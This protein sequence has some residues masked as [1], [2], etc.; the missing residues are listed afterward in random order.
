MHSSLSHTKLYH[1]FTRININN[2]TKA[3]VCAGVFEELERQSVSLVPI[4]KRGARNTSRRAM[5]Y[6][7]LDSTEGPCK[8][9]ERFVALLS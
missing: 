9:S 1:N 5:W 2:N 4:G 6:V 3:N 8:T 7:T